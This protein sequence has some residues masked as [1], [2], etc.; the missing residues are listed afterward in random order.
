MIVYFAYVVIVFIAIVCDK[1]GKSKQSQRYFLIFANVILLGSISAF[2]YTPMYADYMNMRVSLQSIRRIG[3]QEILRSGGSIMDTLI[4]K[5]LVSLSDSDQIYFAF[6]AIFFAIAVTVF[7]YKHSENVYF[8]E[9]LYLSLG[10]FSISLNTVRQFIALSICILSYSFLKERKLIKYMLL[11]CCACLVH[12]SALAMIPAYFFANAKIYK[13]WDAELLKI[14]L[15]VISGYVLIEVMLRNT[16]TNYLGAYEAVGGYGADQADIM[17]ILVPL[18]VIFFIFIVRNRMV[19]DDPNNKYTINLVYC[20]LPFYIFSVREA[21]IAQR[22]ASYFFVYSLL[23][24]PAMAK[25][26]YVKNWKGI[27][28]LLF[29]LFYIVWSLTGRTNVIYDFTL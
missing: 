28:I 20:A 21:L 19:I 29:I 10:F 24:I 15:V 7:L 23:G 8:S 27:L 5:I 12:S 16:Y 11:I 1:P 14:I 22:V 3:F 25:T 2:R 6:A 9:I 13:R 18:V 26:N 4:R 17:G